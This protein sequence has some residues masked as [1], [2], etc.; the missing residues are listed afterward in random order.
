MLRQHWS[1]M[2]AR[3][4]NFPTLR[5]A[6]LAAVLAQAPGLL[7]SVMEGSRE[8]S[9]FKMLFQVAPSDYWRYHYSFGKPT[10]RIA[11]KGISGGTLDLLI[12]N[13]VIPLWFAYGRYFQQEEW[14]ERCFDLLQT[15]PAEQNFITRKFG[16]KGF[17]AANAFDSQ[18]MIGLFRGFCEAQKCL[19]CKVGQSLLKG[20]SK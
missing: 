15:I 14:Q 8:F 19:S 5:L 16:D 7:Q 10:E 1:F 20:Q 17:L 9:A 4:T 2:G 11:S 18:G 13:F 3:P 12:I 6:Q